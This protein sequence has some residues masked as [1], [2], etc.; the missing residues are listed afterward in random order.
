MN[1]VTTAIVAF[2][3]L[4]LAFPSL[5]KNKTQYYASLLLVVLVI[6]FD[7]LG[8]TFPGASSFSYFIAAILQIG[9]LVTL[10]LATGGLTVREFS[11]EVGDVAE[12]VMHGERRDQVI[13]PLSNAAQK[14]PDPADQ[15]PARR[16]ARE[17][18]DDHPTVYTLNSSSSAGAAAAPPPPPPTPRKPPAP[19]GPLPLE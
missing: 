3:F 1:G 2:I 16:P 13:V 14:R 9:A 6:L 15:P 8:H 19:A 10:V 4:A 18:E 5:I 7:A 12:V 11:R 17:S